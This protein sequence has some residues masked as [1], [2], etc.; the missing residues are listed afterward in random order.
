VAF[1]ILDNDKQMIFVVHSMNK[2]LSFEEEP[3]KVNLQHANI[4]LEALAS[5]DQ[6]TGLFNRQHFNHV[7][8]RE[9]TR[10]NREKTY[11]SRIILEIDFLKNAMTTMAIVKLIER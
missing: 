1:H 6:L 10:A 11:L 8:K 4:R 2:G 5:T 7:F 9:L 3:H